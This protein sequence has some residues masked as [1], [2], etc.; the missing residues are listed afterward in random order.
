MINSDTIDRKSQ[1]KIIEETITQENQ[2][3]FKRQDMATVRTYEHRTGTVHH[4]R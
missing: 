4:K 3:H 1:K 2:E